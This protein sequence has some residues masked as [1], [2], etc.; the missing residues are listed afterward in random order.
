MTRE[1]H[2]KTH[3]PQGHPYDE[4]NTYHAPRTGDRHCRACQQQRNR[5]QTQTGYYVKGWR[6]QVCPICDA[7]WFISA[8]GHV[9]RK[10]GLRMPGLTSD[11]CRYNHRIILGEANGLDWRP[12]A[13]RRRRLRWTAAIIDERDA[14]GAWIQRLAT[15]WQVPHGAARSRVEA[16]Y[17]L[18]FVDRKRPRGP[19]LS[20][21]DQQVCRKGHPF[22]AENTYR[23]NGI[24]GC[25]TCR[26]AYAKAWQRKKRTT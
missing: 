2:R 12:D 14:G 26:N 9:A 6:D 7:K 20:V 8:S 5:S 24:R 22:T 18:G 25:R 16:M 15:R 1:Y 19:R 3:C 13:V 23:S 4:E 17:R 10:H 11:D 21:R